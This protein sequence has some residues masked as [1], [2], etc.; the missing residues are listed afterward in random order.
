MQFS[1]PLWA[2]EYIDRLKPDREK[3]LTATSGS[4]LEQVLKPEKV[5]LMKG[6]V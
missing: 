1:V 5:L 3:G 2:G 4:P 6:L